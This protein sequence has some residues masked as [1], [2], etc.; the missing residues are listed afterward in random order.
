VTHHEQGDYTA[1][2]L[3]FAEAKELRDAAR[4]DAKMAR[5]GEST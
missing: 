3:C 1:A 5:R 4:K 2:M